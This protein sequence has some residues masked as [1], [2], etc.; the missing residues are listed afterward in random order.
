M[1]DMLFLSSTIIW[2]RL[3]RD[4]EQGIWHEELGVVDII[5]VSMVDKY[6]HSLLKTPITKILV[7]EYLHMIIYVELAV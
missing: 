5:L 4:V 3:Q 2:L 7:E 6:G 1:N